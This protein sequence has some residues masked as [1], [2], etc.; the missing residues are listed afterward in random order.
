MCASVVYQTIG[1]S[2]W[3]LVGRR[4]QVTEQMNW[5]TF[6]NYHSLNEWPLKVFCLTFERKLIEKRNMQNTGNEGH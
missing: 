6:I 3:I 5:K 2:D 1:K 4:E